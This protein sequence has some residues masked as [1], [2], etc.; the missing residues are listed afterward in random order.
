VKPGSD[1]HRRE[2]ARNPVK[3]VLE[4]LWQIAVP[5][6]SDRWLREQRWVSTRH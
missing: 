4:W 6:M 5:R 1:R 3:R 2:A